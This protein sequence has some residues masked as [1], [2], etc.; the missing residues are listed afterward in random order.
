MGLVNQ[1]GKSIPGQGVVFTE[2]KTRASRRT[3]VLMENAL[4]VLRVHKEKQKFDMALAGSKWR[5][6]NLIFA[7]SIGTPLNRS[8]VAKE[9]K[10]ILQLAQL[11]DIRFHDLRHTA[12]SLMLN[13]GIVVNV[14]SSMLGHS[15][16]SVTSDIYCHLLPGKQEEAARLLDELVTPTAI[17]LRQNTED[18]SQDVKLVS[19][20]RM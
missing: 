3:I 16:P 18:M 6:M 17:S 15:K 12:A 5:D 11:P 2:P 20:S 9:F 14:A 4:Q 8:N 10:R 7:S 1:K 13:N 19:S